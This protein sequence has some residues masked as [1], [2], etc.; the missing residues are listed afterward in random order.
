[1]RTRPASIATIVIAIGLALTAIGIAHQVPYTFGGTGDVTSLRADLWAHGTAIS[2]AIVALVF[3]GLFAT[4][5]TRPTRGGRRSALGLAILAGAMLVAGLAEPAQQGAILFAAV[6][7]ATP[8]IWAFHVGLIALIL[9]A[10]GETR[11]R[12]DVGER[13]VSIAEPRLATGALVS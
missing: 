13:T 2:P 1:M 7:E 10:V 8:F 4:I 11:R 6:D 9:S 3:L 12:S 5:A